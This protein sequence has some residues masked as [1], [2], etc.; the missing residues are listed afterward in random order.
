MRWGGVNVDLL[1]DNGLDDDDKGVLKRLVEESDLVIVRVLFIELGKFL[2]D[3][4][5][6]SKCSYIESGVEWC[7]G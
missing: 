2:F 1:R 7:L 4:V 5:K 3:F 6:G